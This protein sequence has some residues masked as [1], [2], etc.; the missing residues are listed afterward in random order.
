MNADVNNIN[1]NDIN[2]ND[3]NLDV[4]HILQTPPEHV[5]NPA[6]D[7]PSPTQLAAL[8]P[9]RSDRPFGGKIYQSFRPVSIEL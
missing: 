8:A 6:A 5:Y 3:I 1:L 7:R 4:R 9:R 2:L